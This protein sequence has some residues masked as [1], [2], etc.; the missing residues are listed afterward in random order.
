L[1][2]KKKKG[3]NKKNMACGPKTWDE[4]REANFAKKL[5][6]FCTLMAGVYTELMAMA[7]KGHKISPS[8]TEGNSYF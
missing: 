1:K 3:G 7:Y 8:G 4:G 2:Q 5:V 6:R